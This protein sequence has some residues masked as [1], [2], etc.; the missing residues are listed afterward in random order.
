MK[1]FNLA[2]NPR[3]LSYPVSELQKIQIPDED[4][5]G[6]AGNQKTILG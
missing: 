2:K 3:H 1:A 4:R 6:F 5:D